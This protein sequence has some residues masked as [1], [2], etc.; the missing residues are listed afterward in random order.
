[1]TGFFAWCTRQ[2]EN[3]FAWL[4]TGITVHGCLLTPITTLAIAFSGNSIILWALAIA[5]MGATL[6]S[7]LAAMPTRIT[8]PVLFLSILIDMGIVISCMVSLVAM[9]Q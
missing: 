1:M 8:I 5:A 7:N 9:G 3:R 2:E 6:V 4:A